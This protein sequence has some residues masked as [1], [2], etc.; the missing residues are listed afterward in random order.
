MDSRNSFLLLP[1][2]NVTP[3]EGTWCPCHLHLETEGSKSSQ[4]TGPWCRVRGTWG[5][6]QHSALGGILGP[7]D[8][9]SGA[10]LYLW[11]EGPCIVDERP[12]AELASHR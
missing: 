1:P 3:K 6:T 4:H 8:R 7:Q 5:G 9:P 2:P 12:L 10:S 11:P